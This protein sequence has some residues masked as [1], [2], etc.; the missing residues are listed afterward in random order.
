MVSSPTDMV[1]HRAEWI[2]PVVSAPVRNG[3]VLVR[4]GRIVAAGRFPELVRDLPA[5]VEIADHGRAAIMPA[6]VNAHTHVELSA[7]GGKVPFPRSGF[8]DWTR[9][10]FPLR[11]GVSPQMLREGFL[12]GMRELFECGTV[13]CGDITNGFAVDEEAGFPERLVFLEL[14]G[15]NL[16]SVAEAVPPGAA[17]VAGDGRVV[18]V[19]HS[20][21][22]VSPAIIWEAAALARKRGT[23]LS[24][25]VAEH[26]EEVEFLRSGTGFCR[27]L[28]ESLGR[29]DPA[30]SPPGRSPVQ[31]LDGLDSLGPNTLLV[32]AVHMS[33]ADWALAAAGK[34]AVCFCPRS[35]FNLGVGRP[36]IEAALSLGIAAC[37]GTDSLASNTDLNLF[38]EAA[39]VLDRYPGIRPETALAMITANPARAL[40]RRADF[41]A[42]APGLSA[43]L[44][45]V[46]IDSDL[47]DSHLAEAVIDS[48]K[49]GAFQ[50][51]TS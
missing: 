19:P 27:D 18:P 12:G 21:Y 32:H 20:V 30:W 45:A 38:A 29:W 16:G 7:F 42:V 50:W 41:G 44:L 37:L 17:P 22:S 24:I 39:F 49:K 11:P 8:S 43:A 46:E 4:G 5:G 48:G 6:L 1:L 26:A 47:T 40:G 25:H 23:P 15:F 14:L 28:L 33:R 31:Y 9:T 10:F 51:T 3:A 36:D 13:L 2:F 35:N 34:C